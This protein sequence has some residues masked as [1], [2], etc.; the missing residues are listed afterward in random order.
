VTSAGGALHTKLLVVGLSRE[1]ASVEVRERASLDEAASRRVLRAVVQSGHAH[2]AFALSTCNRTEVYA[3]VRT[4]H[5]SDAPSVIRETLSCHTDISREELVQLGYARFEK[6]AVEHLFGVVSGLNSSILGEPEIVAQVREAVSLARTAGTL[7]PL[8]EGLSNHAVTAGRRVRTSTA[9]AHGPVSISAV[10]V[11]LAERLA[12]GLAARR[13]LVIGAGTV[14]RAVAVR[15]AAHGLSE[16]VIANR[17]V[18]PTHRIA[19]ELGG[20]AVALEAVPRELE[21]VDMAV[22]ATG[23]P[24]YVVSRRMLAAAAAARA[25]AG[26]L[27]VL[28]LAV[29]RDVEPAGRQLPG[30][31]LRDIDEIQRIAAA[32]LDNR[33]RELP[34]AWSIVRSE[35][36]RFQ[37]WRA[38]REVEPLIDEL[39]RCAE[40]IRLAELDRVRARSPRPDEAQ[41]MLLDAVTTALLKKLLH[42]PTRRIRRAGATAAGRAQLAALCEVLGVTGTDDRDESATRARLS[43]VA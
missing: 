11:D 41:L 9:I 14:A 25:R 31:E 36:K 13:A 34:T 19:R 40:E 27:V 35:A 17:S 4:E 23:A 38:E 1:S 20:R 8:L 37:A 16:L 42:D 29:P 22:C 12:D 33:K 18:A 10:A 7:G 3:A 30:V 28:D 43:V 24:S 39:R 26:A 2:E 6:A 32:N 21:R 5:A 15:L